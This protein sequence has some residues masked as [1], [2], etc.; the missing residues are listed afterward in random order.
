VTDPAFD[1]DSH[2][3]PSVDFDYDAIDGVQE[4]LATLSQEDVDRAALA[5]TELLR[6]VFCNGNL[7]GLKVRTIIVC[8]IFLKHLRTQHTL[9]GIAEKFG[10]HKQSIGRHHDVFKLRFPHIKTPHMN[11]DSCPKRQNPKCK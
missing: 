1:D 7:E 5:F 6:W 9:T 11:Y 10:L 2:A 3:V 8:W 4:E